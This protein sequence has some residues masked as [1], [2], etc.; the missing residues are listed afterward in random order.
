M[1]INLEMIIQATINFFI[2]YFILYK[3]VFKKTIAIMDSRKAEVEKSFAK[4]KEQEDRAILL[5]EQYDKD[6][7]TYKNEGLKLVESYKRKADQVYG[8]IIEE[9]KKEASN[10]KDRALKEI[11]KEKEK[12]RVEIKE[13][14]V[15]LSLQ[16][17]TRI[18]E[19]EISED[20][21]RE[22]IDEFIAKVGS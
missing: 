13:E 5:K 7:I 6:V 18:L 22:L 20:K 14:I 3:F 8:E 19:K 11:A 21:H 10:I 16:L 2:F 9:S 1:N 4:V 12:A 17:S 15:D